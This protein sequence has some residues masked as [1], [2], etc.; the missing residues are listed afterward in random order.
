MPMDIM[1]HVKVGKETS[2]VN[3]IDYFAFKM[4]GLKGIAIFIDV[5]L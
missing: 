5:G 4:S 1:Q 3:L 2:N